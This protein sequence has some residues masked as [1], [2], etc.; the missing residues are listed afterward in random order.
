MTRFSNPSNPAGAPWPPVRIATV[1]GTKARSSR[2]SLHAVAT[3][4]AD[5]MLSSK[6]SAL[7]CATVLAM[8]SMGVLIPK[9]NTRHPS[10]ARMLAAMWSRIGKAGTGLYLLAIVVTAI[11]SGWLLD[12]FFPA[13]LAAVPALGERCAACASQGW[14]G[15]AAVVLLLL[16][17]PGL[18]KKP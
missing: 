5:E 18:W 4:I 3:P 11:T 6:A 15:A 9:N 1:E 7:D 14:G 16:L 12:V 8:S 17:A 13:A 2:R 10:I